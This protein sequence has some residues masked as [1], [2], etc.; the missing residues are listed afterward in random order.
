MPQTTKRTKST[1]SQKKTRKASSPEAAQSQPTSTTL[2]N[3]DE[4]TPVDLTIHEDILP[5]SPISISHVDLPAEAPPKEQMIARPPSPVQ[6]SR[7]RKRSV[8]ENQIRPKPNKKARTTENPKL[9]ASARADSEPREEGEMP[10]TRNFESV[11]FGRYGIKPWC[12]SKHGRH[13]SQWLVVLCSFLQVLLSIS[14]RQRG[15]GLVYRRKRT[16]YGENR[17]L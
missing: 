11:H 9:G 3:T 14:R 1:K 10:K 13:V 15:R 6:P 17:S 2:A 8:S 7:K 12:V 4:A 5:K 16:C